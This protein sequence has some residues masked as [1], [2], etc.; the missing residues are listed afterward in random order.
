MM[1][2]IKSVLAVAAVYWMLL[3]APTMLCVV[4]VVFPLAVAIVALVL[5]KA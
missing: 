2:F 5:Y 3:S 1:N 4:V